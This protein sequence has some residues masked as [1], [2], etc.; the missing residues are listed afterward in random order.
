MATAAVTGSAAL[1]PAA[2]RVVEERRAL[3]L[4]KLAR[5]ERAS[6]LV[7]AGAFLLCAVLMAGL[8]PTDRSP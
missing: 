8:L 5:R 4:S 6:L 7:S 1:D 3:R 2:H